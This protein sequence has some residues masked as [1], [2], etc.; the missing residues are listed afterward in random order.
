MRGV[1]IPKPKELAGGTP[2][3][4][5][6]AGQCRLGGWAGSAADVESRFRQVRTML[7][8]VSGA[9]TAE[10]SCA[11]VGSCRVNQAEWGVVAAAAAA[12]WPA[13]VCLRSCVFVD[14]TSQLGAKR[15]RERRRCRCR[16]LEV[17]SRKRTTR[18]SQLRLHKRVARER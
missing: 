15:P 17:A 8:C 6:S 10:N 12:S 14:F 9:E 7:A 4:G 16:R 2:E 13:S 11:V 5:N 18:K 3:A 1:S